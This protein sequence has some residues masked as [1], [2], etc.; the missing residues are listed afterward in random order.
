MPM[1]RR[2]RAKAPK[3]ADVPGR[4]MP[5]WV[6]PALLPVL[7]LAAY[8]PALRGDFLWDDDEYITRNP[9]VQS[10]SGLGA[11]WFDIHETPQYYPL[12]FTTFWIEHQLW[13]LD[14][15]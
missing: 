3:L 15:L 11:I 1:G 9:A 7:A 2:A 6:L 5:V 4:R 8:G 12:T 14:P 10:P 13:G